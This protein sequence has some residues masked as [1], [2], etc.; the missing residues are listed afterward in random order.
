[1][2]TR[3]AAA[4][5]P[6]TRCRKEER[7]S[8]IPGT[9]ARSGPVPV[10]S[11]ATQ[12]GPEG[13]IVRSMQRTPTRSCE[14]SQRWAPE[15]GRRRQR[16]PPRISPK[17]P[18]TC[19]R[20]GGRYWDRTSDLFRVREARYRCANRPG[21]VVATR[22]RRDSNPCIRLCRPLPRL[23]ATPPS[24]LVTTPERGAR[25][26]KSPPSG[27]RDSN[28][29]PSPWQGDALPTEP[30]PHASHQ[31]TPAFGASQ[32]LTDARRPSP[33]GSG[34]RLVSVRH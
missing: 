24:R 3:W 6:G 19:T 25:P 21:G 13:I 34:S 33:T 10:T 32:T 23:S 15:G 26:V 17:R 1:M 31:V 8:P 16:R 30:R 29:R 22:W 9:Y 28:P 14:P 20:A 4:T 12:P 27:R 18:L 5:R 11:T 2:A 7:S